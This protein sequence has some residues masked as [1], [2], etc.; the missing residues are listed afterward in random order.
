MTIRQPVLILTLLLLSVISAVAGSDYR[1]SYIPKKVYAT[2][3]FPVTVY[4]DQERGDR[5]PSFEFDPDS[6]TEPINSKPV[7]DTNNGNSFYTFYFKAKNSSMT[8][9][10]LTITDDGETAI[11]GSV[12]I[13]VE[14]LDTTAEEN[15]CGLIA[16]ACKIVTSQVSEFDAQNN[17]VSMT[18]KASEA[19]PE[20]IAV[21]RSLESGIEKIVRSGSDVA[22]EY[23][24]VIPSSVKKVT[25]SYYN[26][27]QNRFISKTISTDYKNS[28]VAAQ[29]NLNPKDSSFDKIK[30]YGL[31]VLALLFLWMFWQ[32]KE[33]LFLILFAICAILLFTIFTPKKSICIQEGAAIYILPTPTSTTGG[34]VD[35]E[36][37]TT[38]LNEREGYYKIEYDNN[39]I[40]WIK[41]EDICKD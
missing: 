22:V 31:M 1:Y 7:I 21:P 28:P 18:I 16:T 25:L 10:E 3:V 29:E 6:K 39:V 4:S 11:L 8:I 20:S 23:Y 30:K 38:V 41:D 34:R 24:F 12:D 5:I 19:N 33:M 2:Q 14:I 13:P 37:T 9:P 36:L 15:F 17:L 40:G 27:L 35:R 26:T 32:K